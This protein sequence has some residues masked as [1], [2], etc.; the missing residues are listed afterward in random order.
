M[1]GVR[2]MIILITFGFQPAARARA[3]ARPPQGEITLITFA[4]RRVYPSEQSR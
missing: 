2:A 3:L 1:G 4:R